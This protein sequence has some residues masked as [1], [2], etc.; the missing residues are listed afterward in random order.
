MEQ[1]QEEEEEPRSRHTSRLRI[2]F[3]R[4]RGRMSGHGGGGAQDDVD[5]PD[6]PEGT[7]WC[8]HG[9][10]ASDLSQLGSRSGTDRCCRIHDLCPVQLVPF[11]GY[12]GAMTVGPKTLSHCACDRRFAECLR[13]VNSMSS[14]G[15]FHAYFN[16]AFRGGM[17]V[18]DDFLTRGRPLSW[19]S[20]KLLSGMGRLLKVLMHLSEK[21]EEEEEEEEEDATDGGAT[22]K[23]SAIAHEVSAKLSESSNRGE[24]EKLEDQYENLKLGYNLDS[25]NT[26]QVLHEAIATST[27]STHAAMNLVPNIPGNVIETLGPG[28]TKLINI[29]SAPTADEDS[30]LSTTAELGISTTTKDNLLSTTTKDNLLSTT[31]KDNLLSTTTED[32]LLSTTTKDNLLST[33]TEDNLLST[34]TEDNHLSTTTENILTTTDSSLLSTTTTEETVFPTT[35]GEDLLIT[36][37]DPDPVLTT[38][39]DDL[40]STTTDID[41]VT[42]TP[43]ENLFNVTTEENL[44]ATTPFENLSTTITKAVLASTTTEAEG[45]VATTPDENLGFTT[46]EGFTSTTPG[47]ILGT[48]WP[49]TGSGFHVGPEGSVVPIE[50]VGSIVPIEPE[51]SIVPIEPEENLVPINPEESLIP[52]DPE[53]NFVPIEPEGNFV[54]IGPE[55]NLVPIE[56]EGNFVPIEPEGNFVPIEPEGNFV[57]IEPEGNFGPIEPEGI[58][59]P[60]GPDGFLHYPGQGKVITDTEIALHPNGFSTPSNPG[61]IRMVPSEIHSLLDEVG[62]SEPEHKMSS[63][64]LDCSHN[65]YTSSEPILSHS[66]RKVGNLESEFRVERND[67]NAFTVEVDINDNLEILSTGRDPIKTFLNTEESKAESFVQSDIKTSISDMEPTPVAK[68]KNWITTGVDVD[69]LSVLSPETKSN[70][71]AD[72]DR[73]EASTQIEATN[74]Y[75]EIPLPESPTVLDLE[76]IF[77]L[78]SQDILEDSSGSDLASAPKKGKA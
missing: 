66:S 64:V 17:C 72:F 68:I 5:F 29:G 35:T 12:R 2:G 6:S 78:F 3:L 43:D 30:W 9:T 63:R 27:A 26:Y 52:I 19:T 36:T 69:S 13:D 37:T 14:R 73:D 49:E 67:R 44:V 74:R 18:T 8:G 20:R 62:I 38:T 25:L 16:V 11:V 60:S 23:P 22:E 75:E 59:P 46:P 40:T 34:T 21:E 61:E 51:G 47:D 50:P 77:P 39:T 33:T 53:G 28:N 24:L 41:M 56:P 55:G 31:T 32:N 1:Q 48:T 15:I 70:S 42:T 4:R 57:P 76:M 58:L 10:L 65:S 71:D 7:M 54:P 45:S